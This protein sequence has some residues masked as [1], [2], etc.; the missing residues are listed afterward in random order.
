MELQTA[1]THRVGVV[2]IVVNN[3]VWRGP[4]TSPDQL[5]RPIDHAGLAVGLGCWG[6]SA[7]TQPEFSSALRRAFDVAREGV[8]CV[9]DAHA[10]GKVVSK[11]LRSLDELGLM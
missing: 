9:V 4:G 3:G 1:A 8:P 10:D 2:V 6:E 5:D 11:L 7:S